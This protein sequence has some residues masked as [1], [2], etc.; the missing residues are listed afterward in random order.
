MLISVLSVFAQWSFNVVGTVDRLRAT[1]DQH[2]LWVRGIQETRV[3]VDHT[4]DSAKLLETTQ[5]LGLIARQMDNEP[6]ASKELREATRAA[7]LLLLGSLGRTQHPLS[8][9]GRLPIVGALARAQDIAQQDTTRIN[10]NLS[11]HWDVLAV[12]IGTTLA[13]AVLSIGLTGYLYFV[14]LSRANTRSAALYRGLTEV[15]RLTA[16]GTLAAG[17]SHEVSNPLTVVKTNLAALSSLPSLSLHERNRL[18]DDAVTSTNRIQ[19]IVSNLQC[20]CEDLEDSTE[21]VEVLPCLEAAMREFEG[22][23]DHINIRIKV[24]PNVFVVASEHALTQVLRNLVLNAIEALERQHMRPRSL[25]VAAERVGAQVRITV[26][27]NGPGMPEYVLDRAFEPFVTTKPVG[28]GTGLGL[29]VCHAAVRQLGGE[30][31]LETSTQGTTAQFVLNVANTTPSSAS[32][33]R[34]QLRGHRL[35]IVDDEPMLAGALAQLLREYAVDTTCSP[36]DALIKLAEK[37]YDLV[38][39]DVRMPQM[40]GIDLFARACRRKPQLR[41]RFVFMTGGTADPELKR[42]LSALPNRCLSKPFRTATLRST[43]SETLE[44][45]RQSAN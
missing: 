8:T 3:Q 25:K 13:G 2:G 10:A 35:L 38:L 23:T 42:R 1:V 19:S 28:K 40:N 20:Y 37:E 26:A 33:P 36:T 30:V 45:G 21:A 34:P 29:F 15:D 22:R 9:R 6:L 11:K 7:E 39:C 5:A 27:D 18:L 24:Q 4:S 32:Y 16:A 44:S 41:D 12:F 43:L 17:V 14:L 31:A